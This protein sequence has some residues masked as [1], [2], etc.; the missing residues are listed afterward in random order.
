MD[1][2]D[3][4][5]ARWAG[6]RE[7]S[8]MAAPIVMGSLSYTVMQFVDSLMVSRLGMDE[9]AAVGSAGVWSYTLAVFFTGIA[10]CVS[11]FVSQSLGRDDHRNAASYAWQGVYVSL[12]AGSSAVLIW[13]AITF[14]FGL[15]G[16][17]DEVTRLEVIYFKIRL[18]GLVFIAW[19][20]ALVGFFQAI[21]KPTIPMYVAIVGNVIN[22]GLNYLLIFGK[23]GFPE[24]G[25]GGAA[26]ATVIAT[27]LQVVILQS[28]FLSAPIHR[29][30]ATRHSYRFDLAKARDF[31]RI[32]WPS[33]VTSFLDLACWSL[34]T[35]V[36]VGR[37]GTLEL[38]AN[39]A[40]MQIM[41]LN[42]MPASGLNQAVAPIVGQWIG[43]GRIEL[44]KARTYTA[45]RMA[46]IYMVTVAGLCAMFGRPL[47]GLF[48]ENPEVVRLGHMLLIMAAL[49]SSFD[50]VSM[51][52]MGALRGAGDTRWMMMALVFGSYGLCLP[53]AWLFSTPLGM[54]ALGA[55]VGATI[56][57][58][59]LS[60]ILLYRFRS[61]GWRKVQ[62]F[63]EDPAGEPPFRAGAEVEQAD[64]GS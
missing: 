23:F 11:T 19:Q 40:A 54:G 12:L 56:Y 13:P 2:L 63:S 3:K 1:S 61:E 4:D 38:A 50:A 52:V 36:L 47:I 29:I 16:H 15:L 6:V 35:S 58:M 59:V 28:I 9:F 10:S 53:L 22:V 48:S 25:I 17:T 31:F 8:I 32:G 51:T 44:A 57:I 20:V 55:W 33:G 46:L 18:L 64:T 42:F 5:T 49:F 62:I 27:G 14:L 43:R 34:F 39:S 21:R 24:W 60:G 26:A 45:M 41:H 30:F 37:F 7:V